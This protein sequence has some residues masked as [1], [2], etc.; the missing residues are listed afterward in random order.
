MSSA[1]TKGPVRLRSHCNLRWP[2]FERATAAIVPLRSGG[3]TRLKILDA[4]ASGRPVIS[5]RIGAEGIEVQDG[6]QLLL[7]DEPNEFAQQ[8]VRQHVQHDPTA[9]IAARTVTP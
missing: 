2:Y 6:E 7:G 8:V 5:T 1:P 4:F 9:L 3:G